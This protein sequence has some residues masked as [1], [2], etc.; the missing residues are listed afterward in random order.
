MGRWLSWSLSHLS[1]SGSDS[2]TFSPTTPPPSSEFTHSGQ[3]Q[4]LVAVSERFRGIEASKG[5]HPSRKLEVSFG[6]LAAT[7]SF[8]W[9]EMELFTLNAVTLKVSTLE[10]L[11]PTFHRLPWYLRATHLN[12]I[13]VQLTHFHIPLSSGLHEPQPGFLRTFPFDL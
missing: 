13:T 2:F 11:I 9:E 8:G 12:I 6:H 5:G 7:C 4:P 10:A 1:S 3:R